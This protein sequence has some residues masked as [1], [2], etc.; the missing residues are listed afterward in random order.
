[1][2]NDSIFRVLF[3]CTGNTCRSAMAQ[4]ALKKLIDDAG[5]ENIE[6]QSAGAGAL[7]GHPASG[8]AVEA[9]KLW[10]ADLT[11][12]SSQSLTRDLIEA[13]DLIL[14]MAPSHFNA[15]LGLSP[16]AFDRTFLFKKF[17]ERGD[18]GEGVIDPIGSPLTVY[19]E[20]FLDITAELERILP[21]AIEM[22]AKKKTSAN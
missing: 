12:H 22:A 20:V 7:A 19:N 16:E 6:I 11:G 10:G 8:F 2:R 18:A 5:L 13:S 15:V 17:P 21:E 4:A 14:A 3:V 1:M 9:V